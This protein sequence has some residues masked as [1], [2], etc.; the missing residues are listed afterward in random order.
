[1]THV[2]FDDV[3]VQGARGKSLLGPLSLKAR[4]GETLVICGATGSG[5]SLLIELACGIRRPTSGRVLLDS[6][7][8]WRIRPA[9]RNVGLLT[10]DAA[11]YDHLGVG[12]NIGFGLRNNDAKRIEEAAQ[13]ACCADL[14]Q[15]SK[16][17]VGSLSGGERRRVALA[18]A[19]AP[20]PDILLLDEPFNGLDNATRHTLRA[21]LSSE[22]A[23]R[24]GT[25]IIA[26]HEIPDAIA[27][28]TEVALLNKGQLLQLG[29]PQ[30]LINS[31]NSKEVA[32][33]F[34][35]PPPA[36]LQGRINNGE[37]E[38]PGGRIAYSGSLETNTLVGVV[39]PPFTASLAEDGL[40]GW[41]VRAH[42]TT[43][44]GLN[45]L[46]AHESEPATPAGG[47]LRVCAELKN[48]PPVL[49]PVKLVLNS[50]NIQLFT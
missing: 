13:I 40:T 48:A 41:E 16:E 5:K 14:L 8:A 17:P 20:D 6:V 29:S 31:P 39:I 1:M 35:D 27:L 7:D 3:H 21:Q 2:H 45:L 43:A 37:L 9:D 24:T 30:D 19:I 22:C 38:L 34:S 46:L 18:K 32:R 28:A 25:T 33:H 26:L 11:L 50:D 42:E 15:G 47:Y 36:L 49:T 4:A 10:Q 12:E 44:A 23:R